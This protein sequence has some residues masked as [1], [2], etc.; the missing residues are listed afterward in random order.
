MEQTYFQEVQPE[1]DISGDNFSKGEINYHWNYDSKGYFNPYRS[2]MKLR[3]ALKRTETSNLLTGHN[4]VPSS[5][6]FDN[7]FQQQKICLDNRC[8]SEINDYSPQISA[9][10]HRMYK[11]EDYKKTIGQSQNFTY[12]DFQ[13]KMDT[14][15]ILTGIT[16]DV[17]Q[18]TSEYEVIARPALGFFDVDGFIPSGQSQWSLT[19]T[20]Q[21]LSNIKK[22]AIQSTDNK[23][24]TD[25]YFN[26]LSMNLYLFKGIGPVMVNKSFAFNLKEINLQ[27]QNITTNSLTQKTFS[28]DPKTTE[29]TLAFQR[30]GAGFID[31]RFPATRFICQ[32][33]DHL[34]LRRFY[35][36]YNGKQ[37]PSPIPDLIKSNNQNFMNARYNETLLYS[38]GINGKLEYETLQEWLDR[39]PY[40]HFSGY[41]PTLLMHDRV[42]VSHQFDTFTGS[43]NPDVLLFNHYIKSVVLNIKNGRLQNV[44][45]K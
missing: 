36:T 21:T 38:G 42:Y 29:L 40:Y 23:E 27:T 11:S 35:I 6:F 16:A 1:R 22:F 41:S 24:S 18:N 34:K 39:G 28:V 26:I 33:N 20:P 14:F 5:Y 8:I 15:G 2:Y 31:T 45:V 4:V 32:G 3:F 37:L 19:L 13:N 43:N 10:K 44:Q 12:D 17:A 9:L 30:T 7:L 25:Y